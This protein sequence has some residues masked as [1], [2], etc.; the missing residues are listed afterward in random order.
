MSAVLSIL[1]VFVTAVL[2][3]SVNTAGDTVLD[4]DDRSTAGNCGAI[5]GEVWYAHCPSG[6]RP[7]MEPT[8][9]AEGGY[10]RE[11]DAGWLCGKP[12]GNWISLS[13]APLSATGAA[14]DR[15]V[16]EG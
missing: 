16:G 5:A 7:G 3:F 1:F 6:I 9:T 4:D 13:H 10:G 14:P 11:R 12:C 15:H 8:K 2:R